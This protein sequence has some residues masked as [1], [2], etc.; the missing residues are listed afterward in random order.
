[1][2]CHVCRHTRRRSCDER[3]R[4]RSEEPPET[5]LSEL[6]WIACRA[7]VTSTFRRATWVMRG[8]MHFVA[9]NFIQRFPR[10]TCTLRDVIRCNEVFVRSS[11]ANFLNHTRVKRFGDTAAKVTVERI[12][13]YDYRSRNE[14]LFIFNTT[15]L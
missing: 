5:S 4:D 7:I 6:L 12:S 15:N 3:Q 9:R 13:L 10:A 1:M 11:E 2:D 8:L 14:F